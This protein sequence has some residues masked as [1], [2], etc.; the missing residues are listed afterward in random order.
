MR[1]DA[2]QHFWAIARGDYGWLTPELTALYRDFGPDDLAPL[3]AAQGIEG[4]ILVQAAPTVAE[5][6]YMLALAAEHEMVKG[7][8]GWVDLEQPDAGEVL[9]DLAA[10]G[11]LVGVR[12]M[13]QDIA[14]DDWMLRPALTQALKQVAAQGLVFDALTLPRHLPNLRTLL[15]RHPDLKVVIDHGSKPQIAAGLFDDWAGDMAELAQTTQACVKLSGLVTEAATD[16]TTEDL[17][18]YVD[19]LLETFGPHRMVW[20]SDWPVCTLASSYAQWCDTTEKLLGT[21]T[22][23]ERAA[24]LG[25]T[26]MK[27][28]G[29]DEAR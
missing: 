15:G 6:R 25:E 9:S 11:G 21:L 4:T 19:H 28:Y 22:Q 10:G 3:L 23:A 7:V 27:L 26:A 29:L 8:V 5:T 12:P 17:R 20:G 1:L 14:D 18:P 13:I 2:H 16:W 24:I